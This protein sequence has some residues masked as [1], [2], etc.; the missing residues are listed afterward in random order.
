MK[1]SRASA[2]NGH[3]MKGVVGRTER[4]I[5]P[6]VGVKGGAKDANGV[7]V[8]TGIPLVGVM[9]AALVGVMGAALVV[10]S[11]RSVVLFLALADELVSLSDWGALEPCAIGTHTEWV[12]PPTP[13]AVTSHSGVISKPS[14]HTA[15]MAAKN[16]PKNKTQKNKNA[17]LAALM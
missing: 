16:Q 13:T 8:A 6:V 11:R 10:A 4:A 9:G 17:V 1:Q 2:K 3:R 14:S 7:T 15:A 5:S 12:T